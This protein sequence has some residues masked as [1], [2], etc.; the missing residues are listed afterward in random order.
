M[1][2]AA[3]TGASALAIS[4]CSLEPSAAQP[5][6][7]LEEVIVTATKR[8]QTLQEVP[9]SVSVVGGEQIQRE[10]IVQFNELQASVPNLQIDQTNANFAIT[11]RGLG[12]GAGNLAFEQSVGLFIDGVYLSR[13]R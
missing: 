9:I 4:I 10:G 12:A 6:S 11:I 2:S 7:T 13:A 8:E 3:L 1:R 5:S